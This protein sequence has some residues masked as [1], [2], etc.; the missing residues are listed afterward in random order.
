MFETDHSL[1]ICVD[2][3]FDPVL[4]KRLDLLAVDSPIPPNAST[5]PV[6]EVVKGL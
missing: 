2:I 3:S 6:K 4:H 1:H 5:S